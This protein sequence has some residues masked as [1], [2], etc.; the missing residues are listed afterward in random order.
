MRSRKYLFPGTNASSKRKSGRCVRSS[1]RSWLSGIHLTPENIEFVGRNSR[2]NFGGRKGC[3]FASA[4][5]IA[6]TSTAAR[7]QDT[8]EQ[9]ESQPSAE[10]SLVSSHGPPYP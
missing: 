9:R 3:R 8:G 6:A 5:V 7:D 1:D 10:R 4:A 2:W